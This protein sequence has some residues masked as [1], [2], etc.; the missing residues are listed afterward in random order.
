[1]AQNKKSGGSG[2]K[3]GSSSASGSTRKKTGTGR[4]S[5]TKRAASSRNKTA[6]GRNRQA[7]SGQ[8]QTR[9]RGIRMDIAFVVLLVSMIFLYASLAGYCG[10]VGKTLCDMMFGFFGIGA[11][12]LPVWI[13]VL[14][15]YLI[16]QKRSAQMP[17]RMLAGAM[18]ILVLQSVGHLNLHMKLVTSLDTPY[19]IKNVFS[20]C[21]MNHAGGGIIGG[22]FARI[23]YR[24]FGLPGSVLAY[25]AITVIAL[26]LLAQRS[27]AGLYRSWLDYREEEGIPGFSERKAMRRE[28]RERRLQQMEEEEEERLQREAERILRREDRAAEKAR[29]RAESAGRPSSGSKRSRVK[30]GSLDLENMVVDGRS[31]K[32]KIS[33]NSSSAYLDDSFRNSP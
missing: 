8:K 27:P 28:R 19:S 10:L 30:S 33:Q 4:S 29:Q 5:S 31:G 25:I 32:K 18:L 3:N 2:R 14:C 24:A 9:E 11:W 20:L 22:W 26:M 23:M 15:V 6:A 17:V 12:V 16:R 13:F 1:M 21:A 7:A